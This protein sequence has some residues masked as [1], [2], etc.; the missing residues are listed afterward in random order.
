MLT[1]IASLHAN[2]AAKRMHISNNA[3]KFRARYGLAFFLLWFQILHAFSYEELQLGETVAGSTVAQSQY[4][5]QEML[6][7]SPQRLYSFS[8][9]SKSHNAE[10]YADVVLSTC[11]PSH[12]AATYGAFSAAIFVFE[13]NLSQLQ[14]NTA[15][16]LVAESARD[17]GDHATVEFR[18]EIGKH[19]F[20]VVTSTT[21]QSGK[22]R[23]VT[24]ILSLPPTP[25]PLPWG[26]DRIDQ[27]HL[28]LDNRYT[29]NPLQAN[30]V[31]VYVLDSGVRTTHEEFR[32]PNGTRSAFH[33]LDV[34]ERLNYAKD[35]TGHGTHV[36]GVIAGASFGVAKHATVISVRVLGCDGNGFLTRLLEGLQFVM[37]DSSPQ[38]SYRRPAVVAMSLSTSKSEALNKAVRKLSQTGIAVVTAAGNDGQDSCMFS[39]ASEETAITVAAS[40]SDDTRPYFSNSGNC[41]DILAPGQNILSAWHTGDHSARVQSGTSFACPHVAGA[42]AVLLSVNPG[43]PS[44]AVANMIYSAATENAVSNFTEQNKNVSDVMNNNRLIYVRSIP[45]NGFSQPLQ[46]SM[47]IYAVLTLHMS[48]QDVDKVCSD[49]EAISQTVNE[50]NRYLA[51]EFDME[52]TE[53]SLNLTMCCPSNTQA[54]ECGSTSSH[55]LLKIQ[56]LQKETLA[57]AAFDQLEFVLTDDKKANNLARALSASNLT[58][59]TEPWVVDSDGNVFWVAPDLREAY[60]RKFSLIAGVVGTVCCAAV[61]T[62]VST[63]SY[64]VRI[65]RREKK[66]RAAHD[67]A[68]AEHNKVRQEHAA[69][70]ALKPWGDAERPRETM[71]RENSALKD[72]ILW[73][74]PSSASL[75]TPNVFNTGTSPFSS[76]RKTGRFSMRTR[77]MF[78]SLRVG[79]FSSRDWND[80]NAKDQEARQEET[81]SR[82]RTN[83]RSPPSGFKRALRLLSFENK[84]I[85]HESTTTQ[86]KSNGEQNREDEKGPSQTGPDSSKQHDKQQEHEGQ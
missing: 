83:S 59:Q 73:N 61:I 49:S 51:T 82:D 85:A 17:C 63:I 20:L 24:T 28:P 14:N 81:P 11:V 75:K 4:L 19:Y 38:N 60:R 27:R 68:V 46:G 33:G 12:L 41:V 3:A 45:S 8:V 35:C 79:D 74:L 9:S 7:A 13:G 62:G 5:Q 44:S 37:E 43:L 18:A 70:H 69:L 86:Q 34:V 29:V 52:H 32:L 64:L 26:L 22:F 50:A 1:D 77:S 56:V 66:E 53:S 23:L 57:S 25:T 48:L 39:P 84:S 71:Q 54:S 65:R 6:P 72:E 21:G 16:N 47:Y 36:A 2:I 55:P 80:E 42:I 15:L 30:T 78:K 31:Y 76:T 40:N 10:H 67:M 58:L